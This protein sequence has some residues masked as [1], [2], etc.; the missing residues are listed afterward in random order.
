MLEHSL[1]AGE[2]L[3]SPAVRRRRQ[4]GER[5]PAGK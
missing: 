2:E 5:E 4:R 3:G 1:V